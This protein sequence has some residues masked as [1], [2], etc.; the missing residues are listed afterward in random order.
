MRQQIGFCTTSDGVRIAYALAG[1]GPPLLRVGGWLSHVEYDWRSPVWQPWLCELARDFSLARFDIRG[2]GLSD[3]TCEDQG[4]DA[5]VRDIEAVADSLGWERFDL[6]GMCQGGAMAL[7]YTQRHP[8]RVRRL[9]LYNSYSKG[10]FSRGAPEHKRTE[11]EALSDLIE[12]GWGRRSGA[13]RE[14]FA[15]LL[16]PSKHGEQVRWWE[17]LQRIT[18]TP[19][20]ARRLWRGFHEI[21]VSAELESIRCPVLVAHVE[22]DAMVP[23]EIGRELAAQIPGA[24]FLPLNGDNHILQPDDPGWR[25]FFR[26]LRYFLLDSSVT[27]ESSLDGIAELT[28]RERQVLDLVARG[29]TN[30][31]LAKEL[32]IAPKTVRNHISTVMGKMD[33]TSRSRMIVQ[34]REAG[35]GTN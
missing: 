6:L 24:R 8:E 1:S 11:A 17:E 21:D 22:G 13:F 31:E 19:E 5:W 7:R 20:S 18:A 23:F 12:V 10:A 15:R 27:A 9:V 35:Y 26:E 28:P 25:P 32:S 30:D 34:A 33:V 16:S 2:S 14:L 3:R 4:L 29:L